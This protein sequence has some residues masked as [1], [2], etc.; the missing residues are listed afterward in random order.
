MN[1]STRHFNQP[2]S[3][4]VCYG[5][6][7]PLCFPRMITPIEMRIV[8]WRKL[9]TMDVD[10][11]MFYL[12]LLRKVHTSICPFRYKIFSIAFSNSSDLPV[13]TFLCGHGFHFSLVSSFR[14]FISSFQ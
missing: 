14:S 3:L 7:A 1:F 5:L 2:Y 10:D 12:L 11:L 6:N 4:Y 9:S 8:V 13:L